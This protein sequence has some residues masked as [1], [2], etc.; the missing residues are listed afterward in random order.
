[1]NKLFNSDGSLPYHYYQKTLAELTDQEWSSLPPEIKLAN[2]FADF[3]TLSDDSNYYEFIFSSQDVLFVQK[4][5]ETVEE[6]NLVLFSS[7]TQIVYSVQAS[8]EMNKI[9]EYFVWP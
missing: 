4:L 5:K 7:S 1:M 6:L 3:G 9:L 2:L 8:E